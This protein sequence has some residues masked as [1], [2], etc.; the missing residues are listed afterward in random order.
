[1]AEFLRRKFSFTYFEDGVKRKWWNQSDF[2]KVWPCWQQKHF[3]RPQ[4]FHLNTEVVAKQGF[5]ASW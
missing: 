3:E 1:M 2:Y 4:L 5:T